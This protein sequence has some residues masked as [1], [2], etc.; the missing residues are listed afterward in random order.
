MET[1]AA[2]RRDDIMRKVA[3]LLAKADS[4]NFGE[5]RDAFLAKADQLMAV[6][7]IERFE[8]EF[9][10]GKSTQR[11]K[12]IVMDI[13]YGSTG[14][15]SADDEMVQIFYQL[16]E[17]V[18]V[19]LGFWGW[20]SAKAVG[21]EEDIEYLRML[22]FNIRLH[23][24][25][26]LEPKPS[27]ELSLID[28]LIMLKEAGLKWDRIGP[29]L[30]AIGQIE[31]PVTRSKLINISNKYTAY[32]KAN[33]IQRVYS[34]PDVWRRNFIQGYCNQ[35]NNRIWEMTDERR[36]AT[37]GKELVLV[38]MKDEIL[39]VLYENFPEKRPHPPECDCD[40]RCHMLKCRDNTCQRTGCIAKRK[41]VKIS[42][43]PRTVREMRYDAAAQ[44]AGRSSANTADLGSARGA[45][46]AR[47]KE[48]G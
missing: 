21:Y 25:T 18:G 39:E 16:A 35:I 13:E 20:R 46:A 10:K 11:R 37:S 31:P 7:A 22:F 38:S 29:L 26:K 32:C 27:P 5:E 24:A 23:L 40:L 48:I 33:G 15:K 12:P 6:Y 14:S 28:N 42:Q 17:M 36:K 9:L 1:E 3:A 45:P 47:N 2:K 19:K 8:L 41:P 4:T 30:A 34:N 44:E 43:R